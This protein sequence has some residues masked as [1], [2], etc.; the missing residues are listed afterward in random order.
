MDFHFTVGI[1]PTKWKSHPQASSTAILTYRQTRATKIPR[2]EMPE[3]VG[4]LRLTPNGDRKNLSHH[5]SQGHVE[6]KKETK[7]QKA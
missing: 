2:R 4:T 3:W 5:L 1:R 7:D 6:P